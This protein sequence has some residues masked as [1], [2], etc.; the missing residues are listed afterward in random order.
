MPLCQGQEI[1]CDV[2]QGLRR[3]NGDVGH[4]LASNSAFTDS[5]MPTYKIHKSPGKPAKNGDFN[6]LPCNDLPGST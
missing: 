5:R 1:G 6:H 2:V 4:G 3:A